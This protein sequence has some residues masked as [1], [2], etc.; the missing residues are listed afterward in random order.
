MPGW[1]VAA[2]EEDRALEL[3]EALAR[4]SLVYIDSTQLGYRPR[5]LETVRE[6]VAERMAARPDAAEI[7]R[8][9]A[10]FYRALAEQADRPLRGTCRPAPSL[11]WWRQ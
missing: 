7:G 10:G 4:H 11:R 2:L 8:R 6:F 3:A 1:L 9:H 5:M